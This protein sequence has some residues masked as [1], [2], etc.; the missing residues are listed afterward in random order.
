M[1]EDRKNILF[2]VWSLGLGGA[3][4]V[5]I[6][7]ACGLDR[8]KFKPM[9]CCLDD[10]GDFAVELEAEG[11]VVNAMHKRRG[12]DLMLIPRLV[13]LIKDENIHLVNTHLWGA[14]CWG[15]VA[16]WLTG[17]P[18][19]VT[20]H[21]V[22][23]WKGAGYRFIDVILSK[24]TERMIVVS[25]E[26]GQFYQHHARLPQEK[27][28]VVLNG[29]GVDRFSSAGEPPAETPLFSWKPYILSVGRLSSEKGHAYLLSAYEQIVQ[30]HPEVHL[31]FAGTGP[32]EESLKETA[33][34]SIAEE[35]IHFV[36]LVTV[37]LAALYAAAKIMVLP[38][39]R[40]GLPITAL[41]ALATGTP[42][43][44]TD[45]GANRQVLSSSAYGSIVPSEDVLAL[46]QAIGEYLKK[47][48]VPELRLKRQNYVRTH[49]SR[50]Q[51]VERT[52][53]VFSSALKGKL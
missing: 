40:E 28:A 30:Q 35:Q 2:M 26:V 47:D 31:I 11:I 43:V 18:A 41:E 6:D 16:A 1:T 51:M 48:D 52:E 32:E 36:G 7:L 29:I 22:D 25:D 10:R 13:K 49:Y 9:I 46:V 42:V 20:E 3:E 8:T 53:S 12:I 21:S 23:T 50:K 45:V 4:R 5:I 44:A 19:V 17:I 39:L 15:R 24:I 37:G 33:K 27:I 34:K 14:N 38:S